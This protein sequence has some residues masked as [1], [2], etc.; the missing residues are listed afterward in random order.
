MPYTNIHWIKL[1]MELLNDKR[2]IFDCNDG[3]K[4]LYVGLLLL[5]GSTNNATPNDEKYLKNRLNLLDSDPNIRQNIDFL[6]A[7]FPK[8]ISKNGLLKFKNF[9]KLHN[10]LGN[11]NGTPKDA[12]KRT[13][14]IRI[15]KI[16]DE[17]IKL[18]KWQGQTFDK[19]FY[20]RT[21]VAINKLLGLT[22][23]DSEIID[24][25]RWASKKWPDMWILETCIK[26]WP[27][28][29]AAKHRQAKTEGWVL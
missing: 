15:D 27:D 7:T 9:N 4:W 19:S 25:L 20:G 11:S 5:A 24:C 1:K 29:Q 28:F 10:R 6:L 13:D 17:F 2:F 12:K 18:K 21:G 23:Q 3:Q 22:N 14:K 16:R 8:L 26:K